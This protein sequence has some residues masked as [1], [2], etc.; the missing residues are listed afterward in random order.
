MKTHSCLPGC[1]NGLRSICGTSIDIDDLEFA[2]SRNHLLYVDKVYSKGQGV[3]CP[4]V[5]N[6]VTAPSTFQTQLLLSPLSNLE[7]NLCDEIFGC[8]CRQHHGSSCGQRPQSGCNSNSGCNCN[9]VCNVGNTCQLDENAVFKIAR[10]FVKVTNFGLQNPNC[11]SPNQVTVNGIPVDELFNAGNSYEAV[12]NS[13]LTDIVKPV[14]A[15]NGLA[16]KAFFL[17]SCAGPWVFDAEIVVEG[18]VNTGGRTCC[19]RATFTTRCTFPIGANIPVSNIAVPRISVPCASGGMSPRLFFSFGGIM[20][21]LNP[22]ICVV[23]DDDDSFNLVL[24][25]SIAAEPTVDVQVIKSALLCINGCEAIF[26]CEG[27]ES[28]V[29]SEEDDEPLDGPDCRCGTV[30]GSGSGSR[31]RNRGCSCGRNRDS[32]ESAS[33][34]SNCGNTTAFGTNSSCSSCCRGF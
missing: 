21:L 20:N 33:D 5:F 26:P 31:N 13:N 11:L 34:N 7:D 2:A 6:L 9:C 17:I 4:L 24:K 32:V 28:E 27:T 23:P 12:F 25:A 18:T 29:E 16:T 30:S 1:T 14:C 8:N 3:A 10:S 15:E 22:T 19:F